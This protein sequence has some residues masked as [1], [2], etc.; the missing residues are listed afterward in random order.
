MLH[1]MYDLYKRHD[2]CDRDGFDGH[3]DQ[4]PLYPQNSFNQSKTKFWK[5]PKEVRVTHE[6]CSPSYPALTPAATLA[7]R[8]RTR[9]F[10]SLGKVRCSALLSKWHRPSAFIVCVSR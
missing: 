9:A 7:D 5:M 1:E 6:C 4:A 3:T 8:T 10:E 2:G